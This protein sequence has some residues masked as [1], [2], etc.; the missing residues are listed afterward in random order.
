M[1]KW[2]APKFGGWHVAEF[3]RIQISRA[4]FLRIRLRRAETMNDEDQKIGVV[5]VD[6]GS[7]REESNPMLLDVVRGFALATGVLIFEAA[8]MGVGEPSIWGAFAP[9]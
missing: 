6:H 9:R 5:L 3:A 1:A 7:R 8:H 4:E 2:A